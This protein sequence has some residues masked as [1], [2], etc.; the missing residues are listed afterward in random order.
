MFVLE[1]V[2]RIYG[3]GAQKSVALEDVSLRVERGEFVAIAGPSGSGKTTLL[4]IVGGIDAPTS[5]RIAIDGRALSGFAPS[6]LADFRLAKLGFVF[7]QFSLIP[8]LT[9]AENV[10][11][12]LLFRKDRKVM[13]QP[14]AERMLPIE[15]RNGR[16]LRC[17]RAFRRNLSR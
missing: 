9:A 6:Q 7:Q 11:L 10:A 8:V 1:S 2:S 15:A 16:I 5:G 13:R 17:G 3:A 12:P 4:N 14:G